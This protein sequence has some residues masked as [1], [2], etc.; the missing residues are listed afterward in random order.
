MKESRRRLIFEDARFAERVPAVRDLGE[1]PESIRGPLENW[2]QQQEQLRGGAAAFCRGARL[3][4]LEIEC[5][6]QTSPEHWRALPEESRTAPEAPRQALQAPDQEAL[7]PTREAV[8][9][10][11]GCQNGPREG[12]H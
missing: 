8:F 9:L 1:L 3:L 4:R 11:A 6:L 2:I 5:V 10:S 12:G 7:G